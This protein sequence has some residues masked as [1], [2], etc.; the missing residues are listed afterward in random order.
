MTTAANELR[1]YLKS[2]DET[3]QELLEKS[4]PLVD[5]LSELTD[6]LAQDGWARLPKNRPIPVLLA[7][8]S[9]MLF[10]AGVRVALSGHSSAIFSVLRTALESACYAHLAWNNQ[11]LEAIWQDRD[12]SADHLKLCRQKF[13]SAV[14]DVAKTL[15]A[16][17]DGSADFVYEAYE[18]SISFGG[19]PNPRAVFLNARV[20]DQD[21]QTEVTFIGLHSADAHEVLRGLV[22]CLD[23]GSAIAHVVR[24]CE[25][26]LSEETIEA[27]N[28][29]EESKRRAIE[30]ATPVLQT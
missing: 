12:Q 25:T 28:R 20:N 2:A 10:L 24:R 14:K 27:L 7:M 8:N 1:T 13:G 11:D 21:N 16:E 9:Y 5:C 26:P 18:Q 30:A 23:F 29:L 19:H 22:P 4:G 3:T 17:H 6:F 15:N